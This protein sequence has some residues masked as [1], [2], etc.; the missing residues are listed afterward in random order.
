MQPYREQLIRIKEIL[1]TN[2]RGITV[3][4]V[5]K[6]LNINRNSVAKYLDLMLISGQVEL[7]AFGPAKVFFLSQRLPISALLDLTSDYIFILNNS[8]D[9]TQASSNIE[10][11]TGIEVTELIGKNIEEIKSPLLDNP[12]LNPQIKD[13]LGGNR[14]SLELSHH[15]DN[16]SYYFEGK[17]MPIAFEDGT[18]GV[19]IA[20][21]DITSQKHLEELQKAKE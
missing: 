6:A 18:N 19:A 10:N 11:L 8:L 5:S 17:M 9:V 16:R 4:D 14:A 7:K 15:K 20:L 21:R 13:V 2:P 1:K 12:K 3:T